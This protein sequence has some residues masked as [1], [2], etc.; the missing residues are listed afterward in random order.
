MS[1]L[2]QWS[3][4]Q[5]LPAPAIF[6]ARSSCASAGEVPTKKC[7]T[8]YKLC[9]CVCTMIPCHQSPIIYGRVQNTGTRSE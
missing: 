2:R 3:L 5:A 4:A 6:A 9:M 1:S 7:M 8:S